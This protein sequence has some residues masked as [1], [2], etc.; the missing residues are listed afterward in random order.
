[1]MTWNTNF[2]KMLP[3]GTLL[4]F[5]TTWITLFSKY[6]YMWDRYWFMT[7]FR[8]YGVTKQHGTGNARLQYQL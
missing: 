6:A 1:M 4:D 3:C 2:E 7:F 5:M 8:A